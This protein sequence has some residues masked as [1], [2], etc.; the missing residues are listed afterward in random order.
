MYRWHERNNLQVF[1]RLLFDTAIWPF[2]ASG[3]GF[4]QGSLRTLLP[5]IYFMDQDHRPINNAGRHRGA[6]FY[7][8]LRFSLLLT[9][10][11][12]FEIV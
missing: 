8:S 5:L 9:D 6:G 1:G 10:L 4:R 3:Q 11:L 7:V 12:S 2:T